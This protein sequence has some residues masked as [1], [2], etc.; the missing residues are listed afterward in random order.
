MGRRSRKRAGGEPSPASSDAPPRPRPA[1]PV[2]VPS[3]R[4]RLDEA[5][6]APWHPFPL[7]ELCVLVGIIVLVIGFTSEGERRLTLLLAG[8]AL[9]S[10]AG[11][12]VAVREHF[13]G[14]RS[15]SSLLAGMT[16]VLVAAPLYLLTDIGGEI[17]LVVAVL[18]GAGVFSLARRAFARRAG[19]LRFRA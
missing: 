11:L 12:E 14:Y 10:L 16:A 5:P 13:A 19:G 7:A 17:I 8:M 2:A 1:P 6:K 3:R 18:V 9:A 15:H 4:A